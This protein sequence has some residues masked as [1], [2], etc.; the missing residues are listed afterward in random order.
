MKELPQR[1]ESEISTKPRFCAS[2]NV[3]RTQKWL[4]YLLPPPD[5]EEFVLHES[6]M[7][8]TP[9]ST[10]SSPSPTS[11]ATPPSLPTTTTPPALRRLL[12]ETSDLIDS[13]T[14]T[15]ILTLLLDTAFSHLTDEKLRSQAFKLP[16][17][18]PDSA[19][20]DPARRIQEILEPALPSVDADH[21]SAD[22]TQARTKLANILA[23][24]TRQAHSIGNGV[25]NEYVQAMEGVRELEAFAA[26]IYSSNFEFE[27]EGSDEVHYR[28]DKSDEEKVNETTEQVMEGGVAKV[29]EQGEGVVEATKG[30][31]EGVWGRIT[32]RNQGPMTG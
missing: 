13:P 2:I 16:P 24:M 8:A 30:L 4:P 26:V 31:F 22:P 14:F 21:A 15:H 20:I 10:S 27:A 6:G 25:P 28:G 9:P 29:V 11:E 1:I 12:D 7:S 32:G 23:V 5:Q 19:S 18:I 17:P 3:S